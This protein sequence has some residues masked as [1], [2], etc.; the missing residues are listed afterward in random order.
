MAYE[1]IVAKGSRGFT[2]DLIRFGCDYVV[3]CSCDGGAG[4]V[5]NKRFK[6]LYL[7]CLQHKSIVQT[8]RIVTM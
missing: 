4:I 2:Y 3:V 1:K 8:L 5:F 7:Y 6:F